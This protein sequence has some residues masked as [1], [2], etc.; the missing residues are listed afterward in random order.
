MLLGRTLLSIETV[1]SPIGDCDPEFLGFCVDT[2]KMGQGHFY[3][4]S[5]GTK[6]GGQVPQ[7][8]AWGFS[9]QDK[10]A[11]SSVLRTEGPRSGG[12]FGDSSVSPRLT[13]GDEAKPFSS[14]LS[15]L[16]FS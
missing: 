5:L 9:A 7:I 14:P 3:L 15:L 6:R 16:L 2:C 13:G 11:R 1:G 10:A 4:S 12:D 8:L